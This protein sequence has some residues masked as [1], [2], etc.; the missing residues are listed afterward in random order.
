MFWVILC[1]TYWFLIPSYWVSS[2]S[3]SLSVSVCLFHVHEHTHCFFV[4]CCHRTTSNFLKE[5]NKF[6]AIFTQIFSLHAYKSCCVSS[7]NEKLM[8]AIVSQGPA[9]TR[10]IIYQ[11]L[12]NLKKHKC[13]HLTHT[14]GLRT[15]EKHT[16]LTH[17]QKP[18]GP[19]HSQCVKYGSWIKISS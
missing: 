10:L 15:C 17:A 12:F 7:W 19:A 11:N 5:P 1:S 9:A 2:N 8:I 14:K 16:F 4:D 13:T 18:V 3:L 6:K